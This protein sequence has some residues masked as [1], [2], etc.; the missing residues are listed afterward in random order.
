MRKFV[1]KQSH[2]L[3]RMFR[4]QSLVVFFFNIWNLYSVCFAFLMMCG[5]FCENIFIRAEQ[6]CLRESTCKYE[7]N[8]FFSHPVSISG[9][10]QHSQGDLWEDPGGSVWYQQWGETHC[11]LSSSFFLLPPTSPF[12]FSFLGSFILNAQTGD[13]HCSSHFTLRRIAY[14]CICK[15]VELLL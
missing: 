13:S 5:F 4:S 8:L 2:V 12:S 15:N 3:A 14:V 6:S 9:F 11:S 7:L 1:V 10:H